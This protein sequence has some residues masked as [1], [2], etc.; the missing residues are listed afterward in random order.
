MKSPLLSATLF[1]LLCAC[2]CGQAPRTENGQTTNALATR[3]NDLSHRVMVWAESSANLRRLGSK[4]GVVAI[5]DKMSSSGIGALILEIKPVH[6][7]VIYPSKVAPRLKL[8]KGYKLD[9]DFDV[10]A[11]TIEEAR[12][13][14]IKV[15][16][17]LNVFS[18]GLLRNPDTG[19]P[20]GV[21]FDGKAD[22]Q[23]WNYAMADKPP[24]TGTD[25]ARIKPISEHGKS[26]AIFV[27]PH[28]PAVIEYE[29]AIIRELATYRPDGII[30][31]RVRFNNIESDFSDFARKAFEEY[32]GKP[33]AHWPQDILTWH[34]D[35]KGNPEHTSGPLFQQWLV[36][37]AKTIQDFFGKA[38]QV[39]KAVDPEMVFGD[40][41]GS[42]YGAYWS[43]GLNWA[44]SSYDAAADYQWAPANWKETG[45]AQLLDLLLSGFYYGAVTKAEGSGASVEGAA[46]VLAK[47]VG[48]ATAY[49][50]SLNLPDYK[51]K[52]GKF[53]EAARMCLDRTAGVMLFDLIYIDEYD[54]WDEVAQFSRS[55][56]RTFPRR[57]GH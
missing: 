14:N 47:V 21:V 48:D 25:E 36:F 12:K 42:W 30:L 29:L 34:R 44:S 7:Q 56:P 11:T 18:E 1:L 2:A 22:W 55:Y 31:D 16:L 6:G 28:N 5:L 23:A 8:W 17:G 33:V 20:S 15:L 38:R 19:K 39:V 24:T 45:Y 4:A 52:P 35:A 13:R 32:L 57:T 41:T 9:T 37:R 27:S 50:G 26:F 54:W 53:V 3:G 51:D 46:D 40:Y 10:I 43:E 49:V